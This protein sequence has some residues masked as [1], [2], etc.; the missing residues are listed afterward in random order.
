MYRVHR[1]NDDTADITTAWS[2]QRTLQRDKGVLK[3]PRDDVIDSLC[4]SIHND[5][6]S[7]KSIILMGDFNEGI[8]SREGSHKKVADLGLVNMMQERLGDDLPK[9]WNRGTL[10]I[11][12]VYMTVDVYRSVRK[13]GYAPFNVI[14][15][16]DH[17]GIFFDL[18]MR[19]LFDEDIF[20]VTP[21]AYRRLKSTHPKHVKAYQ[22]LITEQWKIHKINERITKISASF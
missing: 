16:S 10:A 12:H 21:A 4:N 2:Q 13:A 5:I 19:I 17:R 20:Q 15:M 9:T 6:E 14:A 18:D 1:K 3:N 11:D 8:Q 7:N 22:K